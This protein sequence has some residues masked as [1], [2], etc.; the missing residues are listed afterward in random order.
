[1]KKTILAIVLPLAIYGC[2]D[3]KETDIEKFSN[4]EKSYLTAT[5]T[6]V[7][8]SAEFSAGTMAYIAAVESTNGNVTLQ[9]TFDY[10][11]NQNNV[12]IKYKFQSNANVDL[13][14]YNAKNGVAHI[15]GT[16][17]GNITIDVSQTGDTIVL[18]NILANAKYNAELNE[19][20][21]SFGYT[22]K[23]E[24]N[25]IP[26]LVSDTKVADLHL[27]DFNSNAVLN[28]NEDYSA[29]KSFKSDFEGKNLGFKVVGPLSEEIRLSADLTKIIATTEY[30]TSPI[31]YN[32]VATVSSF[33]ANL[34][35]GLESFD[36]KITNLEAKT[37]INEKDNLLSGN[38]TYSIGGINISKDKAE[39]LNFGSVLVATDIKGLNN[40]KNWREFVEKANQLSTQNPSDLNEQEA[41]DFL[42]LVASILSKDTRFE[43][44]IENKLTIGDELKLNTTFQPTAAFVEL[45]QS[46]EALDDLDV[47]F[48]TK[49]PVELI[50]TYIHEFKFVGKV[51]EGYLITQYAKYLTLNGQDPEAAS[52]DVKNV[53]QMLMML[54]AMQSAPLGVALIKFEESTLF[55][56]I[57][58]KD[59]QWNINGKNLTT[60][61]IFSA[62]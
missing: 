51:T 46:A 8:Q 33:D 32:T 41:A 58:F 31:K 15:N 34:E 61:E 6:V 44:V 55:I 39:S 12:L 36:G 19:K 23:L 5:N 14:K 38:I 25:T 62:F 29:V 30:V 16:T 42:K 3:N 26:V 37:S 48:T 7:N 35:S 45:L 59:G 17:N 18:N 1:M 13:A 54:S 60:A 11:D 40:I 28:F 24:N 57:A 22:A 27:T 49:N 9:D 50:D 21:K 56:D 4:F 2:S 10:V 53:I 43:S 52:N 20:A 47:I